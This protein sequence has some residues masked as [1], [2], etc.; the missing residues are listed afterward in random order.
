MQFAKIVDQISVGIRLEMR[1][2]HGVIVRLEDVFECERMK[3][4]VT[5]LANWRR[6]IGDKMR[7]QGLL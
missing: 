7:I 4:L 6:S 5:F 1:K 3:M 2:E